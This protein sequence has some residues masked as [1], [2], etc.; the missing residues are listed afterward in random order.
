M[1][2]T[3]EFVEDTG[4]SIEKLQIEKEKERTVRVAEPKTVFYDSTCS[5]NLNI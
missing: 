4:D 2:D 5:N 1:E 3:K